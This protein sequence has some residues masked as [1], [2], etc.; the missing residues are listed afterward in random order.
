[1]ALKI[2]IAVQKSKYLIFYSSKYMFFNV[3]L[4]IRLKGKNVFLFITFIYD[5][6]VYEI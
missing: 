1:M 5:I 2:E 3:F 6:F 4:E